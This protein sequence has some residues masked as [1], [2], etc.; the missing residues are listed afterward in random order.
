MQKLQKRLSGP[1]TRADDTTILAVISLMATDVSPLSSF[2]AYTLRMTDWQCQF[3]NDQDQY[4]G[5][6]LQGL[7]QMVAIRGGLSS[8]DIPTHIKSSITLT[9]TMCS[10][11]LQRSGQANHTSVTTSDSSTYHYPTHP[12][13]PELTQKLS[14]LPRGFSDMTLKHRISIEVIDLLHEIT[15]A[16]E[17][18]PKSMPD[19]TVINLMRTSMD[20]KPTTLESTICALTFILRLLFGFK[21]GEHTTNDVAQTHKTV[22]RLV[23]SLLASLC[24]DFR[25]VVGLDFVIWGAVVLFFFEEEKLTLENEQKGVGDLQEQIM[26]RLSCAVDGMELRQ[27]QDT[28]GRYFW[29]KTL[30]LKLE[31]VCQRLN[32]Y[33]R[34]G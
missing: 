13:P 26:G 19:M 24:E 4:V 8:G 1:D 16:I 11:A 12:F 28:V 22:S 3:V 15:Q 34:S 31:K 20:T 25:N 2:L 21:E 14:T 17:T 5:I 10:F 30:D 32:N 33:G 23:P 9:E 27:L 6:H 7:K 18:D 29:H